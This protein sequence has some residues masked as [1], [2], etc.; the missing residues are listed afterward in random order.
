MASRASSDPAI[1][2]LLDAL[3]FSRR[4][5]GAG[6]RREARH[7]GAQVE[8]EA[9]L[10]LAQGAESD[11][12]RLAIFLGRDR[13]ALNKALNQLRTRKFVTRRAVDA[14]Q[15]RRKDLYRVTDWGQRAAFAYRD[16]AMAR[17]ELGENYEAFQG[18]EPLVSTPTRQGSR[19]TRI[20]PPVRTALIATT[21]Q[22]L[23]ARR[24][25]AG[26]TQRELAAR[27]GVS[28]RTLQRM[29]G[30]KAD[31]PVHALRRC[32]RVLGLRLADLLGN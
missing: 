26:L 4:A 29:E 18:G 30:K 1:A 9:L 3:T 25:D 24:R 2:S 31:Q 15:G 17:A 5:F 32:A 27:A 28:P 6:D 13:P 23:S 19:P 11:A 16:Q 10:A 20:S 22:R 12:K 8:R 7:E 14:G 21:A